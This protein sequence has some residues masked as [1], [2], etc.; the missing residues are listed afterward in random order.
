MK[1]CNICNLEKEIDAFTKTKY[2]GEIKYRPTCKQC[3]SERVKKWVNDNKEKRKEYI[4][5]YSKINKD[6]INKKSRDYYKN[7]TE[8]VIKYS[9]E[10]KKNRRKNDEVFRISDN[11]RKLIQKSFL[12]IN[13]KKTSKSIHILGC[14]YE[15]FKLHLE[16]KFESWMNW[17]NYAKYNT[18]PNYGWD[19]DHIIPISLA[20]TV[21]DVIRLN[22]YTNLQP[23][24]SYI[25]RHIKRDK[26]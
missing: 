1:K 9:I 13:H 5:N 7:N 18:T 19:I 14:S 16:S 22:H 6:Y 10:Y 3:T 11:F 23:L 25:N 4:K 2:K 26:I 15:D 20:K 21:E 17:D 8:K 24:C 12:K